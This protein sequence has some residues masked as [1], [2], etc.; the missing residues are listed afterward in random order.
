MKKYIVLGVNENPKYLYYLPL[1]VWAW[2]YFG[3]EPITFVTGKLP[4]VGLIIN[5]PVGDTKFIDGINGYKT[6]TIAQVSRLYATCIDHF[7]GGD[8]FMT[9]DVDMLPLSDYWHFTHPGFTTWGRDLTDYHYP[10]CYIGA[11]CN[12]WEGIMNVTHF[13][14]SEMIERDL[15]DFYPKAKNKW[16]VD[17][18]IITERLLAYGKEKITHI[19]RGTDKR[20]GYPIGRV[21][22]SNWRLDHETLI[23]AHLPHDILT[24]ED[25]FHKVMNLLHHVW[26]QQD[27]NWFVSYHKQFKKLI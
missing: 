16:C 19:N 4:N 13:D 7:N 23:D 9:S 1:V 27:F 25:S 21:D 15:N 22:R 3:W 10:I 2:R 20:T 26:P 18:D 5:M 17:Q 24:N 6:D 8:Y 12:E 11:G 14:Y